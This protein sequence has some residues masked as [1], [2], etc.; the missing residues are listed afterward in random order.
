[1]RKPPENVSDYI[2]EYKDDNVLVAAQKR[3]SM[4]FDKFPNVVVSVSS[5]KD[6]ATLAHLALAE[7]AKR[8]RKVELFFLDQEAEWQSSI[9]LMTEMM[10]HPL[11]IPR[12]FQVPLLM[13]NASSHKQVF[14]DAWHKGREWIHPRSPMAISEVDESAPN[15]FYDFFEWY[16]NRKTEPT[17]FLIGLRSRE[18][19]TRFRAISKATGFEDITWSTRTGNPQCFRFYPLFDW[20]F[21][22]IW[23]YIS[24]NGVK[25]NKAYDRMFYKYGINISIMRVSNLI[26]ERAFKAL[27][28]VQEFEPETYNRLIR[29]LEGVH[30]A[31][32][33][34]QDEYIYSV[35][36][37]PS[38]WQTW[39]A[40]RDYLI[41]TTPIEQRDRFVK[42]FAGQAD[43]EDIA[44]GQCKQ[45]LLNDFE[46]SLP[47]RTNASQKLR[48][49]WYSKL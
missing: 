43:T 24:D 13:T 42:R 29:R 45:I 18:S 20:T 6:S 9:D 10:Q 17:A 38:E 8:G 39:K 22:D 46:N 5:G 40:Y 12:W 25:Y 31:A 48:D 36:K 41:A 21:G 23:K 37:R 49:A 3:I 30:C 19:L 26:H 11:V 4:V 2:M 7:A 14:L 33:Y 16:E 28:D 27:A 15:R 47:V 44:R 35:S 1:M 32:L 34:A